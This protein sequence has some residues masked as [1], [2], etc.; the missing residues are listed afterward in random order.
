MAVKKMVKHPVTNKRLSRVW[1]T[2]LGWFTWNTA[3]HVYNAVSNY[4]QLQEN[5]LSQ[6]DFSKSASAG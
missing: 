4:Y 2:G 5:Q 6:I 1:V 3:Y